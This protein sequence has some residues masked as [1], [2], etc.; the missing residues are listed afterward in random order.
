M[1]VIED[2]SRRFG[3]KSAVDNVS[4]SV[5]AGSFVGVIGRSGAGKSTLLRM[6]NRLS[7]PTAGRILV[8]RA[9]TSPRSRAGRCGDWRAALRH[10]LPAVQ[11]GRPPR[12]ADQR[13]DG[14]RSTT[15]SPRRPLLR[16]WSAR[17]Q[18]HRPLGA[19][20]ARHGGL[21]APARRQSFGRPAAA[22][23]HRPRP[24]AGARDHP[25]RRADRLA[26]PAQHQGGDGCAAAHQQALRHHRAGNLHS[27]DLARDLLRPPGRHGGGPRGVRRRR[28]PRSP[29][30]VARELYGLEAADVL[31]P[32][33]A[34]LPTCAVARPTP[35]PRTAPCS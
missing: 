10:D 5:E 34:T 25:G 7:D 19:G 29:S 4:L 11:P 35:R 22:R 16:L 21:A 23:R 28:R 17:G 6:I 15:F 14:P 30:D 12:R 9:S 27:L 8:R 2:L 3:Q 24:G 1:L 26:R 18:G 31:A 33:P 32:R 20:D 13:P